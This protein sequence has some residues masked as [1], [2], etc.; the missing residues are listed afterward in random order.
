[1]PVIFDAVI[2]ASPFATAAIAVTAAQDVLLIEQ[3]QAPP[4]V[5]SDDE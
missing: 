3:L 1:M 4:V 5:L 2:F